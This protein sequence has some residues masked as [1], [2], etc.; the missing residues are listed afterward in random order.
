MIKRKLKKLL[1]IVKKLISEGLDYY[2]Q[3][4]REYE[5]CRNPIKGGELSESSDSKRENI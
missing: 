2:G 3:I 1:E 4:E 5:F